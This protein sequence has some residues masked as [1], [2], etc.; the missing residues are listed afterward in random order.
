MELMATYS[1]RF[2]APPAICE[3]MYDNTIFARTLGYSVE[4]T[5][6]SQ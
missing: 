3:A 2:Y 1:G 4:V 6:P 5:V